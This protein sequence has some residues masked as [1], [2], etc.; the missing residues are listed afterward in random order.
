MNNELFEDPAYADIKKEINDRIKIAEYFGYEKN[1]S[2][3]YHPWV[4]KKNPNK[5][6]YF[7]HDLPN[8]I[9]DLNA[10]NEVETNMTDLEKYIYIEELSEILGFNDVYEWDNNS[11]FVIMS[12]TSEQKTKAILAMIERCQTNE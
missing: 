9:I 12:A 10:I 5:V 8:Y 11:V 7:W 6:V 1:K 2:S 3:P 4:Y